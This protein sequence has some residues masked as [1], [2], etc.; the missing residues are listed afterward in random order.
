MKLEDTVVANPN[1][2]CPRFK[3]ESDFLGDL[4]G[5]VGRGKNFDTDF[6]RL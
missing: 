2:F 6:W 5:S 3:V 4:F 1:L